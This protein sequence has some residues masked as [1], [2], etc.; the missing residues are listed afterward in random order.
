MT[1][2][3]RRP[4]AVVAG[5]RPTGSVLGSTQPASVV[6]EAVHRRRP[7]SSWSGAA[8]AGER[9]SSSRVEF[10]WVDVI[11]PAGDP[12]WDDDVGRAACWLGDAWAAALAA[13][14]VAGAEAHRGRHGPHAVVPPRLLRRPRAGRG[15]RR[16][17]QG[18]RPQPT[19]HPGLGPVP[20]CRLPTLGPGGA[21]PLF[22]RPDPPSRTWPPRCSSSTRLPRTSAPPSR[23]PSRSR[24][25]PRLCRRISAAERGSPDTDV[26]DTSGETG[27]GLPPSFV[28]TRSA[29]ARISP[30][31][32]VV[33]A[34]HRWPAR[35]GRVGRV[36][37]V[38]GE[39]WLTV[40]GSGVYGGG[41]WGSVGGRWVPPERREP[42]AGI[43][44]TEARNQ[45]GVRRQVRAPA[46]PEGPVGT[47]FG[48]PPALRAALLP[49]LRTRRLHRSDDPG[50]VRGHGQRPDR[51]AE[52]RRA[53]PQPSCGRRP[54]TPSP[55][56][57]TAR[58][59]SP[60]IGTCAAS[61]A[62]SRAVRWWSRVRSTGSR[63]G[64]P[65]RSS[66]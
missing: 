18:G 55:S 61:P 39:K 42:E 65:K 27:A 10:L 12:L 66:A 23:P 43:S 34:E 36:E 45:S 46:G 4:L 41:Q 53:E 52:A 26:D 22:G 35:W 62:S 59:G 6:D 9:C 57:S 19:P 44:T 14:G 47:A 48:L 37:G 8:A 16:R 56:P 33:Q 51:A 31:Q 29:R 20:V 15:A 40:G 2:C 25:R 30:T 3:R 50:G 17:A 49:R 5:D 63:S 24:S 32:A 13:C 38:S 60:S 11:V 21:G 54:A 7:A 64:T 28:S 1:S 58:A